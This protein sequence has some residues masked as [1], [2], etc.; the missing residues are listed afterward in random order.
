MT[1]WTNIVSFYSHVSGW[2][3]SAMFATM[4]M[5]IVY[6]S[7]QLAQ[8]LTGECAAHARNAFKFFK[9]HKMGQDPLTV[10]YAI[11]NAARDTINDITI[12]SIFSEDDKEKPDEEESDDDS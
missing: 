5:T 8:N 9:E 1:A 2:S 11:L 7:V 10:D 3:A 4:V 12:A 6:L